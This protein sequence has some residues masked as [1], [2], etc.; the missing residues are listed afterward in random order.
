MQTD[1]MFLDEKVR[2]FRDINFF[3]KLKFDM[4]PVKTVEVFVT[5]M[6]KLTLKF[7]TTNNYQDEN[8]D[9]FSKLAGLKWGW[10]TWAVC[11]KKKKPCLLPHTLQQI[12]LSEL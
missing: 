1:A 12:C 9:K 11:M 7:Y 4:V 2:C 5:K 6:H 3:P 8:Q 10:M